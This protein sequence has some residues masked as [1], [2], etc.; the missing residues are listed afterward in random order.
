[1]P[2][3]TEM[4]TRRVLMLSLTRR[5]GRLRHD[6]PSLSS[7]DSRGVKLTDSNFHARTGTAY[8]IGCSFLADGQRGPLRQV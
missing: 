8:D 2:C 5:L 1:M 7:A 4:T 3:R 6:T